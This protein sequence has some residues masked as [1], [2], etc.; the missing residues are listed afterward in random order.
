MGKQ[1]TAITTRSLCTK[2]KAPR[3]IS[4]APYGESRERLLGR[5]ENAGHDRPLDRLNGPPAVQS[6]D[7]PRAFA[8]EQLAQ[9]AVVQG[10]TGLVAAETSKQR[11]TGQG[12]IAHDVQQL[13]ANELVGVAQTFF[14]HH[15]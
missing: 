7:L 8:R 13:V 15:A 9:H 4:A 12:H 10:V 11:R 2:K 5:C 14:V 1:A 6:D 3:W